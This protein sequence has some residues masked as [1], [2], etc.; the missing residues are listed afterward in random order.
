MFYWYKYETACRHDYPM[1]KFQD[2]FLHAPN[3]YIS[4]QRMTKR[5]STKRDTMDASKHELCNYKNVQQHLLGIADVCFNSTHE[6]VNAGI[7]FKQ[8]KILIH[9]MLPWIIKRSC[10]NYL[11]DLPKRHWWHN[12]NKKQQ[13][14]PQ[15]NALRPSRNPKDV[16]NSYMK[17]GALQA[18][19]ISVTYARKQWKQV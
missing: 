13:N 8:Q 11:K 16:F 5:H 1:P 2:N 12:L 18:S 10:G 7:G 17:H 3:C 14:Q 9:F 19:R 6:G 15:T 4:Y